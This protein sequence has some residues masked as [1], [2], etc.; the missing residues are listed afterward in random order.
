MAAVPAREVG[1]GAEAEGVV[2]VALGE[3]EGLLEAQP[4]PGL[5]GV[6]AVFERQREPQWKLWVSRP[7][8]A[9]LEAALGDLPTSLAPSEGMAIGPMLYAKISRF[10]WDEMSTPERIEK[11]NELGEA[12]TKKGFGSLYLTDEAGV[13]VALWKP[14][15]GVTLATGAD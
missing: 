13:Q 3:L 6:Y 8:D 1:G 5:D 11:V 12:A 15:E 2:S 10:L 4:S 7:S 9:E 14:S